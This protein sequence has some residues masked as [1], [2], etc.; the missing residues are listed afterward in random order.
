MNS[1][2]DR[3]FIE[4]SSC[5][6]NKRPRDLFYPFIILMILNIGLAFMIKFDFFFSKENQFF[7]ALQA[8][9]WSIFIT[10]IAYTSMIFNWQKSYISAL[11]K[12]PSGMKITLYSLMT[13]SYIPVFLVF[14]VLFPVYY[15]TYP[16]IV[17]WLVSLFLYTIGV[18]IPM[19]FLY[20][21]TRKSIMVDLNKT[22]FLN[23]QGLQIKIIIVVIA[24]ILTYVLFV[25]FSEFILKKDLLIPNVLSILGIISTFVFHNFFM[26]KFRE[27][28][29]SIIN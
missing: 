3:Y 24:L 5:L 1:I 16:E 11:I 27:N 12:A 20:S 18:F 29:Y 2:I 21:L 17:R 13:V 19:I 7:N 14:M 4:L 28:I 9:G 6:R 25:V 22:R 23:F 8:V 15:F 10:P 26:E